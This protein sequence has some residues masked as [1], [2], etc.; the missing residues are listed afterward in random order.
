MN[1]SLNLGYCLSHFRGSTTVVLRKPQKDNHTIS[2]A[3]RPITLL[4]IIGKAMD[5]VIARRLS[6]LVEEHQVIPRMRM[7]GKK[8][9]LI[10]HTL[11]AMIERIYGG[12]LFHSDYTDRSKDEHEYDPE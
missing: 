2:K 7:G 1:Q 4:N 12:C 9:R 8:L 6:Y 10:E 11:H 5:A 3:Y